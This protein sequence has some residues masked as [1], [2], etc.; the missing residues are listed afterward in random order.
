M[1]GEFD[2][3]LYTIAMTRLN[4]GFAK[5][6]DLIQ[7]NAA[8]LNCENDVDEREE[9]LDKMAVTI[10]RTLPDFKTACKEFKDLYADIQ[11]DLNAEEIMLDDYEPFFKHV[12]E[13][14]P[15]SS[16]DLDQGIKGIEDAVSIATGQLDYAVADL[17]QIINQIL[18]IFT[19]IYSISCNSLEKINKGELR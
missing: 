6:G 19:D 11:S 18:V 7:E 10:K 16:K 15:K 2:L 1:N 4:N 3:E 12:Q 14:F 5:V 9:K 17:V 8:I 13:T